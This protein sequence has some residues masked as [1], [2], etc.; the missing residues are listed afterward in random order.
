MTGMT[1]HTQAARLADSALLQKCLAN[2]ILNCKSL[3]EFLISNGKSSIM[4]E[5]EKIKIY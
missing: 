5:Y 2:L 3:I 4:Y 1:I